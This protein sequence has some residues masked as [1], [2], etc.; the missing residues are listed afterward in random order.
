MYALHF[1][2]PFGVAGCVCVHLALLHVM[3]SGT[4]STVPGTTADGDAFLL[5]W[6]KDVIPAM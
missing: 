3:G 1:L 5:Y 6:Y 4:A 2:L